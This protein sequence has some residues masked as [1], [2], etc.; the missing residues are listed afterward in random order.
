VCTQIGNDDFAW[1]ATTDSKSR[2]N[3]LGLLR[4]GHTDYVI[5]DAA[6]AYMHERALAGPVIRQLAAHPVRQFA[7]QTAWQRHLACLGI[8]D[9]RV[10]PDPVRIATEGALWGAVTAHGFLREAVVVSD[11]AGQFDI[12]QHALCRVGGDVAAPTPHRPGRAGFPH[13]VLH[14][15]ASLAAV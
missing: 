11:D 2:L 12:G 4:A 9:L 14:E 1:F 10:M 6:L 7:D 15:R 3:F 13:P 5:N 8:G